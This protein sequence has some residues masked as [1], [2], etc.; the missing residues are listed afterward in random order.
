MARSLYVLMPPEAGEAAWTCLAENGAVMPPRRLAPKDWPAAERTVAIVDGS[1]VTRLSASL[2]ARSEAEARTTAGYAVEDEIAQSLEDIHIALG[3]RGP[4][5]LRELRVV[6]RP[7][8]QAWSQILTQA[9]RMDSVLVADFDLLGPGPELVDCGEAVIAHLPE[10]RFRLPLSLGD[11][12]LGAILKRAGY[13]GNGAVLGFALARR[14]GVDAVGDAVDAGELVG[15]LATRAQAGALDRAVNLRQGEFRAA[16]SGPTPAI[17]AWRLTA[18]LAA[19]VAVLWTLGAMLETSAL[20]SVARRVRDETRLSVA[21]RFPQLP[22]DGDVLNL[23]RNEVR[24]AQTGGGLMQAQT[25][26]LYGALA[27]IEGTTLR[28]LNFD[29]GTGRLSASVTLPGFEAGQRLLDALRETGLPAELGDL[30]QEG[31]GV[32]TEVRIGGGA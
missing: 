1:R 14:L 9:G 5:G 8:M 25:A 6:A 4:D 22:A 12:V 30:R 23:V 29:A 26:G 7:L 27:R 19:G 3:P 15:L 31:A 24:R 11:D 20:D 28:S 10:A 13:D 16:S 32:V 17:G 18:G 21:Q 2:P